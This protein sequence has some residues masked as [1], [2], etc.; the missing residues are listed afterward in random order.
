MR[1]RLHSYLDSGTARDFRVPT[2]ISTCRKITRPTHLTDE[3][4]SVESFETFN[5]HNGH[6]RGLADDVEVDVLNEVS[7][8]LIWRID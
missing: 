3:L 6:I 8:E 5:L 4:T 2:H 7:V 1:C